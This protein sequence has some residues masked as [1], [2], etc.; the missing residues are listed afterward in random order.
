MSMSVGG[1]TW[2]L[3]AEPHRDRLK[4]PVI[5]AQLRDA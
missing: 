2:I 3:V 4:S 1:S 5:A